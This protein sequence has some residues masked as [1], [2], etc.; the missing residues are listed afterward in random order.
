MA[1]KEKEPKTQAHTPCLGH[2]GRSGHVIQGFLLGFAEGVEIDAELLALF[3]EVAAFEAE[4]AGDI[5]HVEI[6]A[7]DFG[8]EGF[9]LE[10]FGAFDESALSGVGVCG[11]ARRRNRRRAGRGGRRQA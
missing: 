9:A 10:G 5:G 6:V 2:S 3:V 11:R 8:E 4:G 7:A 1:R